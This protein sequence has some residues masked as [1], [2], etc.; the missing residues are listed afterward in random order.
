MESKNGSIA[1]AE[2][3]LTA[4]TKILRGEVEAK[5][6]EMLRAAELLGKRYGLFVEQAGAGGA[7]VI[8][9]DLG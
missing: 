5:P 3:I 9:D 7:A 2:E 4:L 8:V 1:T 6:G